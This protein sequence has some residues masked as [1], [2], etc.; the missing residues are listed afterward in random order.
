MILK[1]SAKC[2]DCCIATL[3]DNGKVL[4]RKN[5]YVPALMPY[6][7]GDY[8]DIDIDVTTGRILNWKVPTKEQIQ[9]FIED[10]ELI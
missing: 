8:V 4:K 7:G 6:E 5:G 2:D 3:V 9:E 1:I 10:S